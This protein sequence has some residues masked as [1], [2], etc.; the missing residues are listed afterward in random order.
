TS[1][2][3]FFFRT[4]DFDPIIN[5]TEAGLDKFMIV[6]IEELNIEELEA[7]FIVY[8]NPTNSFI[9]VKGLKNDADYSLI[10]IKGKPVQE[11]IISFANPSIDIRNL[12]NGFYF[13][14]LN[15]EV[16]KVNKGN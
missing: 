6:N 4:G 12:N 8:P 15:G 10:D 11:G 7:V 13:M 9:N 3:Q 16:Y 14:Q 1:T 2:M 5:I